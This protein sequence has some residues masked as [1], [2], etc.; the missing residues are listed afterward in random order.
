V[1]ATIAGTLAAVPAGD[2]YP[3]TVAREL[4]RA[5]ARL[6]AEFDALLRATRDTAA[7]ALTSA[8]GETREGAA[9]PPPSARPLFDPAPILAA[10]RFSTAWRRWPM[11][12]IRRM[13]LRHQLSSQLA[14]ALD[15]ALRAY[16]RTL[17]RWSERYL[18]ELAAQFNAQAGF[19]E[20]RSTAPRV[21]GEEIEAMRRDLELLRSWNAR[22]AA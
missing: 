7:H 6:G 22:F 11:A 17:I 20:V 16:A 9:L 12:S 4:G 18:D 5:A 3:E 14:G 15:D 21:Q 8:T 13:A 10:S 19:A 1:F 2:Q